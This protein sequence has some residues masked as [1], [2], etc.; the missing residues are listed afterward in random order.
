MIQTEMYPILSE[1]LLEGER[2]VFFSANDQAQ[3]IQFLKNLSSSVLNSYANEKVV[4]SGDLNSVMHEI[5]KGGGRPIT[6]KKSV[7]QEI[8]TLLSSQ[9]LVDTW[10]YI[11][12][13]MQGFPCCNALMKIQCRL[14]YFF[15]SKVMESSIKDVEILP[16]I[17]SDHSAITLSM[18]SVVTNKK[19][20][21]FLESQ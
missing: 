6:H 21:R 14:D 18:L 9:D 5:D 12:P 4:R 7:I 1:V 17:F 3:Q 2:F 8:N 10:S 11:H 19:W 15:I 16:N 13:N 20:A